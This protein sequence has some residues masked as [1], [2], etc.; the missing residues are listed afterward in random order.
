M[1]LIYPKTRLIRADAISVIVTWSLMAMVGVLWLARVAGVP[2][3]EGAVAP[4]LGT[5][6]LSAG[7]H[8]TLSFLHRCPSCDKHPTIQGLKPP[9]PAF[10]GQS[11]ADGWAGV[12]L[13][14]VLK[15]HFI[16]IHCGVEHKV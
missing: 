8:V 3:L 5:F 6:F 10:V 2:G 14:V 1:P 16:C 15:R 12:V 9:H 11:K 7:V 4:A 13:S